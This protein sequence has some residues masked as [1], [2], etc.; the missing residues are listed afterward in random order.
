M[1]KRFSS[2]LI[3]V[4][5]V[6]G[7]VAQEIPKSLNRKW[8]VVREI[9]TSTICCWGRSESKKL[10]GT[11]IEY[12]ARLFRWKGVIT[13]QFSVG[14]SR[15]SAEAF[16]K[17]YSGGG[18]ADSQV[19]FADLGIRARDV[20]RIVLTHAEANITGATVEIPGDEVLIKD[21]DTIIFSVCNVYFEARRKVKVYKPHK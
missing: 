14:V 12:G 3:L 10:I 4:G 9:P 6:S 1:I 16:H 13:T 5:L 20:L 17:E 2:L 11:E 15:I 19:S 21:R 8:V 18:A 7:S